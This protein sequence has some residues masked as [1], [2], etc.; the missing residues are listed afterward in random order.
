[1]TNDFVSSVRRGSSARGT[2]ADTHVD[3]KI[4]AN[5]D[6]LRKLKQ[7]AEANGAE[8]QRIK[9]LRLFIDMARGEPVGMIKSE[10]LPKA[11]AA[12]TS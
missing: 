4:R 5:D 10:E 12:T 3:H 1:M 2:I 7:R 11:D 9:E 8:I 6:K